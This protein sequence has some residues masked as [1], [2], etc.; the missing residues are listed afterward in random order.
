MWQLEAADSI[1]ND[2]HDCQIT[3]ASAAASAASSAGSSAA[4]QGC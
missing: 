4:D 2:V 3:G 1:G